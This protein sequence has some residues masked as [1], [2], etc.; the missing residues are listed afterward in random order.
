M[1]MPKSN[2]RSKYHPTTTAVELQLRKDGIYIV[3]GGGTPIADP[4]RVTAFATSGPGMGPERAFTV[5]RF[6][7]RRAKWKTEILPSSMLTAQAGEFVSLLST[8]GY[9]WPTNRKLWPPII[10]A[11]S[12]ERPGSDIRVTSVPGW[13]GRFFALPGESYGPN[14]PDRKGRS[15]SGNNSSPKNACIPRVRDWP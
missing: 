3:N 1:T 4:I 2:R 6:L 8:R 14:G 13:H 11:L 12:N 15:T 7:N 5:V 10:A 9:M